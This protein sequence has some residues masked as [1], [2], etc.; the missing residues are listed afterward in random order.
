M[1]KSQIIPI[2][3]LN[4]KGKVNVTNAYAGKLAKRKTVSKK[5][6]FDI[7]SDLVGCL[8]VP[9]KYRKLINEELMRR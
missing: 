2:E 8:D 9:A 6:K 7:N 4:E 3:N 5:I 1:K